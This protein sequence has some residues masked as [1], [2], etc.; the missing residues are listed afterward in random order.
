[1]LEG[2]I[3]ILVSYQLAKLQSGIGCVTLL[4]LILLVSA[5]R[6]ILMLVLVPFLW[7]SWKL[8]PMKICMHA[9]TQNCVVTLT[10]II[11]N[12]KNDKSTHQQCL[13]TYISSVYMS[14][15]NC[16]L[17]RSVCYIGKWIIVYS[18]LSLC[19]SFGPWSSHTSP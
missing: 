11:S 14:V 15:H 18:A 13:A 16:T 5:P 17:H 8:H 10:A 12:K 9:C 2:V 1:M 7:E 6:P 3:G 19:F 4:I